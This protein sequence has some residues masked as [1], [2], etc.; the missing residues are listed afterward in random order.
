MAMT[1]HIVFAAFDSRP[2]TLSPVMLDLIRQ[3][4]GFGGLLMTDDLSMQAL[5]GTLASRSAA[6]LAAGCDLV[7]YCKGI[8]AEAEA[9]AA[10]AGPMSAAATLRAD[11]ALTARPGPPML[12]IAAAEA[13]FLAL[14][15]QGRQ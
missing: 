9:V 5:A 8:L 1:A 7:L 2:A 14:T 12:D 10:A 3:K 11:A 13:E 4:I 6:A 15:G